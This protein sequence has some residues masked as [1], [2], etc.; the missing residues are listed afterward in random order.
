MGVPSIVVCVADH[1]WTL[2]AL[3]L[4]SA[5]ARD[6]RL[7]IH[8]VQFIQVD[9]PL[10]LGTDYGYAHFSRQ[11]QALMREY[12]AT[13]EDYGVP[14]D[15]GLYQYVTLSGGIVDVVEQCSAQAVFASL[16][17]GVVPWWNRLQRWTLRRRLQRRNCALFTLDTPL[18]T[19]IWLPQRHPQ[20]AANDQPQQELLHDKRA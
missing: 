5:L 13:L 15:T 7:P 14:F 19:L 1:R 11:A 4:A 12:Q 17:A 8:L 20:P 6:T 18:D 3:H 10:Q 9:H 2:D 16:P